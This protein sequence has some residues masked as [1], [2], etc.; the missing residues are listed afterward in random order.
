MAGSE[1][2]QNGRHCVV[3]ADGHVL[4]PEDIWPR[5]LEPQWRDRAIRIAATKKA[6][7]IF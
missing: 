7:N 6:W 3:D 4:E 2:K 5:F 1:G